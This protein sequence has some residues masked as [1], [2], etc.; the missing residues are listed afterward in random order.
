MAKMHRKFDWLQ[1]FMRWLFGSSS[2]RL[3]PE[4]GDPVPP[5][6]RAFEAEASEVQHRVH[7]EDPS[8]SPISSGKTRSVRRDRTLG[9]K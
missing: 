7:E 6:I 5:E 1:R 4:F 8:S 9:P 2:Q 3:P